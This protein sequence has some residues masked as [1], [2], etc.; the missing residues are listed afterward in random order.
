MATPERNATAAAS[1]GGWSS[2]ITRPNALTRLLTRPETALVALG[3]FLL[4]ML[5]LQ[6]WLQSA[7]RNDDGEQFLF[8]QSWAI[9]Y[10]IKNPPLIT[11]LTL[12]L[13][14]LTGPTFFAIRLVISGMLFLTCLFLFLAARIALTDQRLAVL[15][16]LAPMTL[17][18]FAWYPYINLT[19][20]LMLACLSAA[21]IWAALALIARP[22]LGRYLL[23]G[24]VAGLGLLSKYNFGLYLGAT[25]AAFLVLPPV[26]RRVLRPHLAMSLVI[27]AAIALPHYLWLLAHRHQAAQILEQKWHVAAQAANPLATAATGAGA[28]AEAGL[29]FLMPMLALVLLIFWYAFVPG[30]KPQHTDPAKT[31]CLAFAGTVHGLVLLALLIVL[32]ALQ[33]TYIRNHHVFFLITTPVA[34]FAQI[35]RHGARPWSLNLFAAAIAGCALAVVGTFFWWIDFNQRTCSKCTLLMPYERYAEALVQQGFRPG[36]VLVLGTGDFFLGVQMRMHM[37]DAR[38]LRP[39]NPL[40]KFYAPP[41]NPWDGNCAIVWSADRRPDLGAQVR[42]GQVPEHPTLPPGTLFGRV[43]ASLKGTV[44]A[45]PTMGYAIVPGGL[46]DCR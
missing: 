24:V 27:A 23:F 42:A 13:M 31:P 22:V 8:T 6:V 25:L 20:T 39:G 43:T 30:R 11:W 37:P 19:H 45:A 33:A 14:E 26:R 15:A 9:G 21:L 17:L 44:R 5:G 18:H 2:L 38:Y 41:P 4:V 34:L 10:D 12:A 35:D 1:V 3:L 28:L 40:K 29:S 32:L 7:G 46:G 16:G 36:T